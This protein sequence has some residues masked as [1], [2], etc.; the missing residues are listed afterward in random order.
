MFSIAYIDKPRDNTSSRQSF[1]SESLRV[2]VMGRSTTSNCVEF[3]HPPSKQV[4]TSADYRID[5]TLAAGPIFNLNYDGGLFFN[6]YHNEA[7]THLMSTTHSTLSF[8]STSTSTPMYILPQKSLVFHKRNQITVP[9][10]IFKHDPFSICQNTGL[11][12]TIPMHYQKT[13]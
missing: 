4:L 11:L 13:T 10:R 8:M 12:R 7:D 6:T 5:P 9:H 3:Y 2:I 1:H